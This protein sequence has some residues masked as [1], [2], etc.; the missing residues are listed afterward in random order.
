MFTCVVESFGFAGGINYY[1]G[2]GVEAPEE[3]GRE[4]IRVVTARSLC[5][6]FIGTRR[7]M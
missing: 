5:R 2:T 7:W 4:V 1:R 6:R 3:L